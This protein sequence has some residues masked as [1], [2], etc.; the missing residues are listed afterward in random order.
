MQLGIAA[1]NQVKALCREY[2]LQQQQQ[3]QQC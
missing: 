3:Q 1:L 2:V